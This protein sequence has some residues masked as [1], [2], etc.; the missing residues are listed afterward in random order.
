MNKPTQDPYEVLHL[1]HTA[2]PREV[3]RA[4][5][6]LMRAHHPDTSPAGSATD[7]G[8][9]DPASAKKLQ[10]VMSAY[11]ILRDPAKRAAYDEQA[12]KRRRPPEAAKETPVRLSRDPQVHDRVP[13]LTG[14]E[15][16]IGP[17][18]WESPGERFRDRRPASPS[19]TYRFW[20]IRR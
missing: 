14:A 9:R 6:A 16:I 17:V 13:R 18:R 7:A 10:D 12:L 11:A 15:L 5:R 2:T 4:Y 1:S 8:P 19:E 3:T 20:W